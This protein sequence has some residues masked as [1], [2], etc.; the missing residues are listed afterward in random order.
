M[1]K[2]KLGALFDCTNGTPG[3]K[4]GS[5]STTSVSGKKNYD[6]ITP[7]DMCDGSL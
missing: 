5:E 1:L 4:F 6:P 2:Q 7:Y 3:P